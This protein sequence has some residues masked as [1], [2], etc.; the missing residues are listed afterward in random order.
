MDFCSVHILRHQVF[1][2]FYQTGSLVFGGDPQF[3]S[4]TTEWRGD[5]L[6]QDAFLTGYAACAA[7]PGPMF[8]FSYLPRLCVNAIGTITD[9]TAHPFTVFLPGFL[10]LLGF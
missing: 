6:S 4:A 9:C 3:S 7:V 5:Q 8:T 10:L 2:L 1:G